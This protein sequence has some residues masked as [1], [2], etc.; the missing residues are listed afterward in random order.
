VSTNT[1]SSP[2][3]RVI[4]LFLDGVGI[5]DD[6]PAFNPLAASDYAN[7]Y[8]TLARLLGGAVPVL[9]TGRAAGPGAHLVPLDAQMGVPGRPQSATGQA[10]LLTGLN[11]PALLGEH[12][13]PRPDDRVRAILNRAGIFRRLAACGCRPFFCNAYPQRY[14]DV[15]HSGRRRLSAVPHAAVAGG[16]RLLTHEDLLAGRGLAADF[17][18]QGWRDELGYL[19]A[20]IYRP[21]EAGALLWRIAQP[22]DF[23]FFEHWMTDVY[24]HDQALG[25]AIAMLQR[26]DSFLGGLAIAADLANT[27]IVVASDHGNVEDCR[28]GKHTTNPALGLLI[29]EAGASYAGQIWSL[30]DFAPIVLHYLVGDGQGLPS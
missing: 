26:F 5:G 19:T 27:L 22:Y 10:A 3:R 13:G 16:Q 12:Y 24:G 23:L 28:H 2:H 30:A 20:P 4:F 17:T 15:I 11:A 9:S 6:D 14:F 7:T 18:N 8:P 21:E 29:G 25:P 1:L